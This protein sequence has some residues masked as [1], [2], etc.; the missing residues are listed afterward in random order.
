MNIES[1]NIASAWEASI[2]FLIQNSGNF[3]HTERFVRAKETIGTRIQVNNP[4]EEPI[5][6][7]KYIFGDLFIK[8][9]RRNIIM[10]SQGEPSSGK[11]IKK[12]NGLASKDNNQIDKVIEL[13]KKEKYSRRAIISLWDYE[14]DILSQHPPCA[15]TIQFLYRN[16]RLNTLAYFRSN[17]AWMSLLPDMIVMRDLTKIIADKLSIK[18]GTYIHYAAS[19]H[20]YE[21]DVIP[22]IQRF[23][24]GI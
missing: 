10:A 11:R 2:L 9:Y 24:I 3:I 5:I 1:L 17:D 8:E 19:L 23:N 6:S 18:I 15:C 7:P 12:G 13:L 4:M 16:N 22:A 20:L 21:P 14:Q